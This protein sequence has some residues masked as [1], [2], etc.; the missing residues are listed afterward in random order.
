M[1]NVYIYITKKPIYHH[2]LLYIVNI[3]PTINIHHQNQQLVSLL[4][5]SDG[6]SM[7]LAY[8]HNWAYRTARTAVGV[9][10]GL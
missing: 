3:S 1:S 9:K 5:H 8:S 10:L 6:T 7:L 4:F 2:C